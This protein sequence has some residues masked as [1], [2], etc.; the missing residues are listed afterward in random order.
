MNSQREVSPVPFNLNDVGAEGADPEH[1]Q[2]AED[3]KEET[4][5]PIDTNWLDLIVF[6]RNLKM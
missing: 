4:E 3:P 6:G 2:H 1:A 5:V